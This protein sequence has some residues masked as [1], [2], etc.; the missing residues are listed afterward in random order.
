MESIA[1]PGSIAV[2]EATAELC[3]GYFEVRGLGPTTVKGVSTPVSVYEV[4]GPGPLRTHFELSTRRGLT[5]FVGREREL[6][7]MRRALEQSMAGHG[8]IVAVLAEAGTG[9]SRLFYEFKAT[10]PAECK[11]LEAYSVSH[12]KASPWLPVLELLHGYFGITETDDAESRR[13]KVRA[14]LTALDP[15]I[16][17]T[18]PYLFGLLGIVE[19]ADPH[20]QMDARI[21]RQRTLDAI[22]RITLRDSLRQPM[23]VILE[24]LHWIDEQTQGLLDLLADSAASARMLLLF[25]YRPEYHHGWANK[26]YYSQV[27]LDP[28]AGADGATML[29]ALLGEGDELSPLKRLI[30]ERTGGNPFFIE[31]I[32]QGLFEDG[33]LVRNG[34]VRVT[35]SLSQLRLPPTVQGMLAARVDHLPRPQK[36]L[37][38]TLA[39]I[40]PEAHLRL[41]RQITSA[42]EVLL[43]QDL[44][45]LCAAEFIYEQPVTGDT[46]FVFKHALTQEVAYSLLLIERRKQL[47]ERVG[48][49]T[50]TLFADKLDDHVAAL[51]HHYS[52]SD[53]ADKAIDYLGRAGQQAIQRSAHGEAV[54]LIS[55]AIDLLQRLPDN[56]E[57]V[58]RELLL[59]LSLAVSLIPLKSWSAKEVELAF[60][61]VRELCKRLGDPPE[62]F[63]ALLGLFATYLLRAQ[64]GMAYELAGQLL[65][66]AQS[67]GDTALLTFAH[68]ALGDTLAETGELFAAKQNLET[69]LSYYDRERHQSL[70]FRFI[71]IDPA[72]NCLSYIALVSCQLGFVD[73]A[74]ERG[75]EAVALAQT[76]SHPHSL[77]FAEGLLGTVLL[78]RREASAAQR[79]AERVI[80]LSGEHGFALW[81]AHATC[82][83]GTAIASQRQEASGITEIL[84]G[85]SAYRMTGSA[86]G[87]PGRL[88]LLVEALIATQR[89]EEAQQALT[90]ALVA[91]DKNEG[92]SQWAEAHRLQGELLLKQGTSGVFEA[93]KFFGRA[94]EIAREQRAKSLELRATMSLARLLASKGRRDEA[95]ATLAEIYDWFTEG[96]DLPDLK[97]AKALL[98]ELSNSP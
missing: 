34:T 40:G 36:D 13:D 60:T 95:R 79:C 29:G 51:A 11:V 2:S 33:V 4:L 57:C 55:S 76:L 9:K 77:A 84:E 91:G 24:D 53:N 67:I 83:R 62:L 72:V 5:R 74:L 93:Q 47:H 38:Q 75:N 92:R 15:A 26:S 97:D 66:K 3:E 96:F 88:C 17:D 1:A 58:Q 59:Q 70:A 41:L 52:H 12:G 85:M 28:L 32:V 50:E 30:A 94:I 64:L 90:E 45:D 44:A 54:N 31:E 61:R 35:R 98:N 19:G 18:L 81:L 49:S 69:A 25:N 68:L 22:K 73:Q 80:A 23:V 20:T 16:E 86:L 43:S 63:P 6:E 82:L 7:Q 87:R 46:E 37:L 56:L 89:F 8:Q 14:S 10:I 78:Y 39:V 48:W 71:G 65:Q 27:R 21:K 42:D